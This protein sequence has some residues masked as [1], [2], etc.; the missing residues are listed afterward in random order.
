MSAFNALAT[1]IPASVSR[2][3][4]GT[5]HADPSQPTLFMTII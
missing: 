2:R 3:F 5:G 4:N 1:E